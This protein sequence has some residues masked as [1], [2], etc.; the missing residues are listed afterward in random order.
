M[1]KKECFLT[2]AAADADPAVA[3]AKAMYLRQL[4]AEQQRCAAIRAGLCA[5]SHNEV[6][7]ISDRD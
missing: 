5:A 7:N 3:M 4:A 1:T 2:N 6:W